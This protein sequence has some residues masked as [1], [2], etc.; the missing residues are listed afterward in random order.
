MNNYQKI[1]LIVIRAE[2][3]III[4]YALREFFSV[5]L[6]VPA[7]YFGIFPRFYLNIG[8]TVYWGFLNFFAG[9]LILAIS[10]PVAAFITDR[11][12]DEE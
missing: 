3:V 8:G 5:A 7:L 6:Y 11:L 2:A 9:L 1:A 10:K 4:L 12:E